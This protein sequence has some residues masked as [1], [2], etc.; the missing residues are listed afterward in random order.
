MIRT[1]A[2]VGGVA[3][4]IGLSQFPEFSQQYL[5]R[6]SGAVGELRIVVVGFDAAALASGKSRADALASMPDTGFEGELKQTLGASIARFERLDAD[7]ASLRAA[8]PLER[9]AQPWNMADGDLVA[10]TWEDFKPAVPVTADG[11]ISAAIGF[12]GGWVLV[13]GLLGFL[14]RPFRTRRRVRKAA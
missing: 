2:L 4:A 10:K 12:A 11:A 1:M 14:T 6:L 3:G 13:G 7:L 8:S 5:Q 9:L